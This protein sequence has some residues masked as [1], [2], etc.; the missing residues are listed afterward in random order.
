MLGNFK[1]GIFFPS[2]FSNPKLCIFLTKDWIQ[3]N[4][5]E[6]QYDLV[7]VLDSVA[8]ANLKFCIYLCVPACT[9]A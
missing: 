8:V 2:N 5:D 7:F 6:F 4:R 1:Y 3:L 9:P